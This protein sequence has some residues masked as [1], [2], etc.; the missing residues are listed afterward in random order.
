VPQITDL[1]NNLISCDLIMEIFQE[2]KQNVLNLFDV[3]LQK[4]LIENN[5]CS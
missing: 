3:V 4:I 2:A 5:S 1:A